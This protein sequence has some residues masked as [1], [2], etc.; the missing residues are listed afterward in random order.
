M[1]QGL[2][3]KKVLVLGHDG[4]I[5]RWV[6][7]R[8]RGDG[9]AREV[10]G[11]SYPGTDLTDRAQSAEIAGLSGPETAVVWLAAIK[12][13]LGDTV[14]VFS[15]NMAI[16]ANVCSAL[17]EAPPA[18]L[19]YFSSSAVYG[20]DVHNTC[21]DESTPVTPRTYYGIAKYATERLILKSLAGTPTE[22]VIL[23]PP[24][25]Y[26]PGDMGDAYGP[27]G[28]VGA[29]V[30]G[31]PVTLWGDGS[32]LREFLFVADAAEAV[33]RLTLGESEVGGPVTVLN[34]V[35]GRSWSFRDVLAQVERVAGRLEV[36]ERPRS[37][38]KV[39]NCFRATALR[40]ALPGLQ[41]TELGEGVAR[42]FEAGSAQPEQASSP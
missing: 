5:G 19:V 25:I 30:R 6:T 3:I 2:P 36:D 12:K 27:S 34:L 18:R 32:E 40:A 42:T 10:I 11:R 29:A 8:L 37:K 14:D 39:D 20:E 38:E 22:V 21:I 23:R 15:Q 4:F 16:A 31:E 1:S 24:V 7:E 41:F 33:R 17:M 35:Q 13:Q 9:G 26:G 28:F